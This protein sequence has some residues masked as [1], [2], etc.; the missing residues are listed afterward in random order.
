LGLTKVQGTVHCWG[1]GVTGW[2]FD[3]SVCVRP[4]VR[5]WVLIGGFQGEGVEYRLC[6]R[7]VEGAR[8]AVLISW[9]QG[10][11]FQVL[12][13]RVSTHV[14]RISLPAT[15]FHLSQLPL[16]AGALRQKLALG[17]GPSV[18]PAT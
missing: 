2:E 17:T 13:L 5:C 8:F 3:W 14:S 4:V 1:L 18:D 12:F 11:G 7:D 10:F 15:A 16:A 6:S 9:V